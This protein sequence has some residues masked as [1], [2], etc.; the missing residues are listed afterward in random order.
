MKAVLAL[1][2]T[3]LMAAGTST[4]QDYP[5]TIYATGHGTASAEPD[6]AS[7]TFGVNVTRSTPETAVAEAARLIDAAMA[8]ARGKG[9]RDRDM[10]TSSYSLWV[11]EVWDDYEYTYT[12]EMEYVVSHY[13]Q[14]DVRDVS[15]LGD[16]LSAVVSA[17]A[18][19]VSGVYF[20]VEDRTPLYDEARMRAA[21]RARDK[22]GQLAEA[23]GVELGELI[24]ISEWTSDYYAGYY[25]YYGGG[26]YYGESVPV[27]PGAFTVTVEVSA[28]Y[29]ILQ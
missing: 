24:S 23:F 25:D 28:T 27:T 21:G 26:G 12:G 16:I 18:N 17:G 5:A 22:A 20:Q 10:S 8:A 9:L 3:I 1:V 4:A 14:A 13:V 29:E 2:L 6:M 15:K 19:S 7:I 11:Q